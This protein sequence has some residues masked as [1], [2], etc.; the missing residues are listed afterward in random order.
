M[1][2]R[3]TFLEVI[4]RLGGK[5]LLGTGP[6]GARAISAGGSTAH[7]LGTTRMGS[8]PKD[9][10]VNSFG[11]SWSVKNLF[12]TDGGVFVSNAEKNPTLTILA[13][14]WRSSAYLAEEARKGNL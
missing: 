4:D 3:K 5:V 7:E 11:R 2:I 6:G 12:V 8:S 14:S 10:V 1:H 9:S 13:L